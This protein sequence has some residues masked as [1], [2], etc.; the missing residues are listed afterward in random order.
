MTEAAFT[1]QAPNPFMARL[2]ELLAK[3]KAGMEKG[4]DAPLYDPMTG[5]TLPAGA[6]LQAVSEL[7][8]LPGTQKLLERMAWGH[9]A[10]DNSA[11]SLAGKYSDILDAAGL[12]AGPAVGLAK[13]APRVAKGVLEAAVS[14][15]TPGSRAGQRGAIRAGGDPKLQIAHATTVDNLE[16]AYRG[17]GGSA[18]YSPS[19]GIKYDQVPDFVGQTDMGSVYLIPKLGAFDPATSTST[20]YNRDAY[21]PRHGQF[22]GVRNKTGPNLAFDRGLAN[23][24]LP[25][26]EGQGPV[27]RDNPRSIAYQASMGGIGH[28]AALANSPHFRSYADFEASPAGMAAL[29]K[30]RKESPSEVTNSLLSQYGRETF[31]ILQEAVP[32]IS[33]SDLGE[34]NLFAQKLLYSERPQRA[35]AIKALNTLNPKLA[36]A[37]SRLAD[38]YRGKFAKAPSEY[39]ELQ[40]YG[41]TPLNQENWAGAF[42]T[43]GTDEAERLQRIMGLPI[44]VFKPGKIKPNDFND[45]QQQ[46]GL[47][48]KQPVGVGLAS[49]ARMRLPDVKKQKTGPGNSGV[50]GDSNSNIFD[51]AK[52]PKVGDAE[53]AS[54]KTMLSTEEAAQDQLAMALDQF[55]GGDKDWATTASAV[56]SIMKEKGWYPSQ[57]SMLQMKGWKYSPPPMQ[58]ITPA[59]EQGVEEALATVMPEWKTGN[60]DPWVKVADDAVIPEDNAWLPEHDALPPHETDI[61]VKAAPSNADHLLVKEFG[62]KWAIDTDDDQ[63]VKFLYD[64]YDAGLN[65]KQLKNMLQKL[66]SWSQ[67]SVIK[68]YQEK[69]IQGGMASTGKLDPI[70]ATANSFLS[71]ADDMEDYT[72]GESVANFVELF[73]EA[74]GHVEKTKVNGKNFLK[75]KGPGQK[76]FYEAFGLEMGQNPGHFEKILKLHLPKVYAKMSELS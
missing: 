17:L 62:S 61:A 55:N 49:G 39:A 35:E 28:R 9:P 75:F 59:T 19:L 51:V 44:E 8:G 27:P 4:T 11:P 23:V 56:L 20:L 67:E 15:P 25:A 68:G 22:P 2:A 40:H 14:G 43:G 7:S 74:G 26:S 54:Y 73:I 52:A 6:S 12:A 36:D 21:L 64:Q 53:L 71:H 76:S 72:P 31:R 29:E 5:D 10:V 3:I 69:V 42:V 60:P 16:Q 41:L 70:T 63:V 30:G 45:F 46:M 24:R 65:E 47:A 57:Q 32:G 18:L 37:I 33:S 13:G 34:A 66:P 38:T 1:P 50:I 58:S 48:R